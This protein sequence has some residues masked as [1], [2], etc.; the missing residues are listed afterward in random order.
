MNAIVANVLAREAAKAQTELR[1]LTLIAMLEP[2]RKL[3]LTL[4]LLS[5][6]H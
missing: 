5:C 3:Q 4:G 2:G 1:P 6:Y